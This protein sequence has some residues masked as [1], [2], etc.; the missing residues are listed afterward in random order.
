M[1]GGPGL[2]DSFSSSNSSSH[3]NL[4]TNSGQGLF[5]P[6]TSTSNSNSNSVLPGTGSLSFLAP[7]ALA[8]SNNGGVSLFPPSIV[9]QGTSSTPSQQLDMSATSV[10]ATGA[11]SASATG[12]AIS[13]T[14]LTSEEIQAFKAD[15]FILG[16]I[17][18][19]A[20]PPDLV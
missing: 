8:S 12:G 15:K 1:S 14:K 20:P 9:S 5:G 13:D 2:F 11:P 10:T 19:H 6:I 7:Q 16:R 18:E 17:P 4:F 3:T